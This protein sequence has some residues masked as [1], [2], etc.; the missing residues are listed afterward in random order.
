MN[1]SSGYQL[2]YSYA[3]DGYTISTVTG[4]NNGIDYCDPV[5]NSCNGLTQSWP[6]VTYS[7][8]TVGSNK[9]ESV[10]DA[11]NH[12][13]RY[14]TDSSSRLVGIKRPSSSTDNVTI[15]YDTNGRVNS[16][17][18]TLATWTYSWSLS[19]GVLTG[20]TND[21]L[22]HQRVTTA[23]TAK[24]VLLTDTD[25]L[26]R[27]TTY[28]Y[29]SNGRLTYI[30]P[31][32]GTI[33]G[34]P[35][36]TP[37]AG[38][39][40]FEYDTR[41]NVTCS[42]KV[43]KTAS[44]T[45][46]CALPSTSDKIVTTASYPSSCTNQLTCNKPDWVRGPRST[47]ATDTTFQ[48]DYTYDSTTGFVTSIKSPAVGGVRP[49][50]RFSYSGTAGNPS[51]YAFYKLTSGGSPAQ[52]STEIHKLIA[53]SACATTASC[54]G[55]SDELR[56]TVG[57]GPQSSGTAN[58]LQPVSVASGAGDGS[59]TATT[60]SVYD[61]V[62]NLYT[63]DGP[64]PGTSDTIRYHYDSV[65]Q[66][67]GVV[68]PDPDGSG[69]ALK[70]RAQRYTYNLDG[71]PTYTEQGTVDSQ[72]DPDWA[73]FALL[74]RSLISYDTLGRKVSEAE[75]DGSSYLALTQYSYDNANRLTCTAVRMN[76][77]DYGSLP[78]DACTATTTGAYGPDR[79]TQNG[80]DAANQL[81]S[82]IT[83]YGTSV[84]RTDQTLTY[85]GNGQVQT[86]KDAK[87]NLT[88]YEYDGFDR[89]A[90]LRYPAPSTPNSSSTTD[91]EQYLYDA[92]SNLTERRLRDYSSNS[93]S[94]IGFSYDALNRVT[95]KNLPGSEPDVSYGYDNLG[96]TTSI[97]SSVASLSFTFDQL[98]RMTRQTSPQGNTDYQYDLAN[99]R[100]RLTWP[101]S[102]Y[103]TYDYLLTND[104]TAIRENG[105]TSGAGVLATF[106][107]DDAGRRTMLTRGNGTTTSYCYGGVATQPGC[108]SPGNGFYFTGLAQNLTSTASDQNL[109]FA[110]NPAGQQYSQTRSNDAYSFRQIYNTNR[111]YTANGL[112]Q[113][114]AAGNTVPGYDAKGNLTSF[115]G[116]TYGYS[117]E[118]LLTSATGTSGLSYD[119]GLRLYQVNGATTV[120]F[121]Y[122]GTDMIG[123]YNT[124]NALQRRYVFGPETDEPL[125]W[126]E[127]SGTTDRRWLHA[128]ERGSI[129]AISDGS[130]NPIAINSYDDYGVPATTN[131]GR[132]GYTGQIWLG[133]TGSPPNGLYYFKARAYSP[134][135][136]RFMQTDPIGYEG[137][138]NLYE[139]AQSDPVNATDPSGLQTNADDLPPI[140]VTASKSQP[141]RDGGTNVSFVGLVKGVFCSI[142]GCG[143]HNPRP[144]PVA[145]ASTV[146]QGTPH[147]YVINRTSDCSADEVFND[148]KRAGQS[149]PGA[150]AA[151]ENF[152]PRID[153]AG[154]NPISQFVNSNSRTIINTTLEGHIFYPGDVTIHVDPL[155]GSRSQITITG[156][157]TG[158]FATFNDVIGR[159]LFGTDAN[160]AAFVCHRLF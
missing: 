122:D 61:M 101:D 133:E 1:S 7:T 138:I 10:T 47:S 52:A 108:T 25:A 141:S 14:T 67:T 144:K 37:T 116:Q 110:I 40:K 145:T 128:D 34:G 109:T 84:Q 79:I 111:S 118:N 46:T 29:D 99:R 140:I 38:Y 159:L 73:N 158:K 98:N 121:G 102:F 88:T 45:Q 50:T 147:R 13:T 44:G 146:Q 70:N 132:F 68:G 60:A 82:V 136:G 19:S 49:E 77:N 126:Y 95:A 80:Y 51:L 155:S 57:Y 22:S 31:P 104:M 66:L 139:Y 76:R 125:V 28:Q 151:R 97:S 105:A 41:G 106:S 2:K 4:I 86:L 35:S 55:G 160:Q 17:A 36:G 129:T 94:L 156:T 115:W 5:A 117:S 96:R 112:N 59:L 142:F 135:L 64:L 124:S 30:V 53:V 71:Q 85:T 91:Y 20:T 74:Q 137:G 16:V 152:T 93:S 43:S 127:G 3:A 63:V 21:P 153:L 100:T 81:T 32:E 130:G 113:Y 56:T 123:E 54:S 62:G 103:V 92:A 143:H 131:I 11:L 148:F 27:T 107:Y 90:K 9:Q 75:G 120:R 58:N 42:M 83:A 78:S 87:D 72:S 119:P 114:S 33:V 48:T 149:A 134:R 150:H 69:G 154:N 6:T 89:Q 157:G 26:S 15:G 65:R 18:N 12:V 8:A 23:D 39:T 24:V